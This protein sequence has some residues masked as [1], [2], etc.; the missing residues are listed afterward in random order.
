MEAE[1]RSGPR[2]PTAVPLSWRSIR[3]ET[4]EAQSQGVM[5]DVSRGGCCVQLDD[6]PPMLGLGS[7]VEI[8]LRTPAGATTTRRGLVVADPGA[9]RRLHLALRVS[10]DE[11]DLV[12]LLA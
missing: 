1:R 8:E 11:E 7:V 9:D 12:S 10:N 6:V 5:V 2:V 3:L 4:V